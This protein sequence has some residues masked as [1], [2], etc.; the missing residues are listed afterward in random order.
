MRMRWTRRIAPVAV[1]ALLGCLT[2]AGCSGEDYGWTLTCP[3][4]TTCTLV[5]RSLAGSHDSSSWVVTSEDAQVRIVPSHGIIAPGQTVTVQV[6]LPAGACNVPLIGSTHD[7]SWPLGM[8]GSTGFAATV[9][10]GKATGAR[11]TGA[12]STPPAGT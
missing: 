1:A 7:T 10:T 4:T 8:G 6:T 3:S 2:L 9:P 5:L 12:P 11:C